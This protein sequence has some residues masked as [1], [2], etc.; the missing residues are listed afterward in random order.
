MFKARLRHF[1]I[2]AACCLAL[3]VVSCATGKHAQSGD[4]DKV[5]CRETMPTGSHIPR[6]VCWKEHQVQDRRNSD[7]E[8][9][10]NMH[11]GSGVQPDP[12]RPSGR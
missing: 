9:V 3:T 5:V 2:I 11:I 7:Q 1:V 10:R 6:K 8:K 12:N 4:N